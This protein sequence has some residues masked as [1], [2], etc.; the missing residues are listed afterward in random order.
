[1]A[2]SEDIASHD[3]TSPPPDRSINTQ[4]HVPLASR[5]SDKH[6][7]NIVDTAGRANTHRTT[8]SA[9]GAKG[10]WW[11]TKL[12][13]GMVNDIRRRSPYYWSDWKDAW[14]YRVVPVTIYMYCAKYVLSIPMSNIRCHIHSSHCERSCHC[15]PTNFP[16]EA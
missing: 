12:F 13:R 6:H 15:R 1:M 9:A 14:D 5:D 16:T 7:G 11:K 4:L 8:A 2:S 3:V 10:Q